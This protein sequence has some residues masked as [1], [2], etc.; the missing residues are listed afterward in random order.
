MKK[1]L[2]GAALGALV[3]G[4]AFADGHGHK[5]GDGDGE[6]MKGW[7][8]DARVYIISPANGETVAS[9]FKVQFGLSGL[10]I[11]PAGV[12]KP[13]TGHHHLLINTAAPT[14][15]DLQYG[16][17]ATDEVRHFGGGQT[18]T[19]LTL[20]A[21]EHTLQLMMGDAGHVPLDPPLASEITTITVAE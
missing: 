16:L 15:E 12:E 1:L 6:M 21:G 20:P 7:P 13:K 10:G 2:V 4:P 18:E 3:A 5:H 9:P 19:M 14:G 8:K 17:P 11:A